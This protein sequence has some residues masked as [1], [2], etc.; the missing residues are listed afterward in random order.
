MALWVLGQR[1]RIQERMA[2]SEMAQRSSSGP[3][4]AIATQRAPLQ[5][6]ALHCTATQCSP[7]QRSAPVCNAARDRFPRTASARHGTAVRYRVG[8]GQQAVDEIVERR[9]PRC[10]A[11]TPSAADIYINCCKRM[12]RATN[13][14]DATCTLP[15]ATSASGCD[16]Q[17]CKNGA[18]RRPLPGA[19]EGTHGRVLKGHSKGALRRRVEQ[20]VYQPARPTE[21]LTGTAEYSGP[22]PVPCAVVRC[23]AKGVR[24]RPCCPRHVS[25]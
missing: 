17:C 12:Q 18:M 16:T 14:M 2:A 6:S 10:G 19:R 11:A 24:A 8:L 22:G 5:R 15:H 25:R 20:A 7:L 1:G 9:T 21:A 4:G 3:R 23:A 13:A